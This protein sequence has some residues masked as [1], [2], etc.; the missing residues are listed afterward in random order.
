MAA[1]IED[2]QAA[3]VRIDVA[4][5]NIAAEL[6]ALKDQIAGGGLSADVEAQVLATLDAAATKLEAVGKTDNA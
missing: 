4:T 2:F 1:K 3:I 5:D 6:K